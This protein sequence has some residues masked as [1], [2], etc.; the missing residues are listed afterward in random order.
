MDA[1][2]SMSAILPRLEEIRITF[3]GL[4]RSG[5]MAWKRWIGMRVLDSK[6]EIRDGREVERMG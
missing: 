4:E 6:C 3:D 2:P 5:C 1:S